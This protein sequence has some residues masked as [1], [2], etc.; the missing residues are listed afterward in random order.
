MAKR[1]AFLSRLPAH[2]IFS[3]TF[4]ID[5]LSQNGFEVIFL[6][7]S[8]LIDGMKGQHLYPDQAPLAN[9]KTIVVRRFVELDVFVKESADSTVFIDFVAGLSEFNLNTGRVFKI[10]KKYNAKY[11]VISNGDIPSFHYRAHS[12]KSSFLLKIKKAVKKPRLLF[13]LFTRKLIVYL[14]KLSVFYQ[15]PHRVFGMQESPAVIA[16][17]R[18]YGMNT[19][20]ITPINTRDYDTYLEYLKDT[21][22]VV[23]STETCVFLDDGHTHH[24][25]FSRFDI[26]PLNEV[27][28]MS[29]MN[30]FFD[31]VEEKTGLSVII[32]GHPSSRFSAGNH[33][34]GDRA[35]IQ[36]NTVK[37]VAESKLV[38]AHSST[39]ISFPV[40]FCK[41]IVLVV[42][43][44]MKNRKVMMTPVKA[45]A[46]SLRLTPVDVDS[47]DEVRA[48]DIDIEGH[49][50]YRKYLYKYV[51]NKEPISKLTWEIVAASVLKD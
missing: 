5:Y 49:C 16:Y 25:D 18:K 19:S 20:T 12:S 42:T 1:I 35:F 15:K 41:P 40:L 47:A 23:T 31:S 10:L 13:N 36:G 4:G 45:F 11:Y 33:P 7:V 48:L 22:Q 28:Y 24:P 27:E 51:K 21:A 46:E 6:D 44:E 39:S 38:I 37:L 30:H 50:H 9:C 2:K 34:Y 26:T 8:Y 14:T 3:K 32:A 17:L 29:S 43:S